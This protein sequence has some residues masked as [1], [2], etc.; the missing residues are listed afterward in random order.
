MLISIWP[1]KEKLKTGIDLSGGTILVQYRG[2]Q[3]RRRCRKR[4]RL[5]T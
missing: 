5:R 2:Q 4:Q 1:P 3:V